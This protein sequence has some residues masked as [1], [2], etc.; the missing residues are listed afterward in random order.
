MLASRASNDR[1]ITVSHREVSCLIGGVILGAA[2]AVSVV[3]IKQHLSFKE[4]WELEGGLMWL[5]VGILASSF[6]VL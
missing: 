4:W 3:R 5:T 6:L 1:I 2:L